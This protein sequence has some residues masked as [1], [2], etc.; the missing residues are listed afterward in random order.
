[1]NRADNDAAAK[2]TDALI[3][4]ET[5]KV[6]YPFFTNFPLIKVLFSILTMKN[7]KLK[8]MMKLWPSTS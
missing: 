8:D 2:A 3:N 7:L 6:I 4:F 1:M 5:V